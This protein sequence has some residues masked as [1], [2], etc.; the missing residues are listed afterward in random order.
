MN[1]D[2]QPL[3][4]EARVKALVMAS[5]AL[6][7]FT[8]LLSVMAV[9]YLTLRSVQ[10]SKSNG[11]EIEEIRKV[12]TRLIDCTEPGGECFQKGQERTQDAVVGINEG[13][14]AVIVAA[15]SCQEDGII[16]ERAL[17]RCTARRAQP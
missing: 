6:L 9:G 7:M 13:T 16:E 14:L 8:T 4:R 12:G 15:I 3:N 11:Q 5:I 2:T 17:A 1:D 10:Q